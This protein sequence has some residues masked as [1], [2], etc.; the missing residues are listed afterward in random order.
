[1]FPVRPWPPQ[2][3]HTVLIFSSWEVVSDQTNG[4]ATSACWSHFQEA[5]RTHTHTHHHKVRWLWAH[6]QSSRSSVS[7]AVA[8]AWTMDVQHTGPSTVGLHRNVWLQWRW[9][10]QGHA[11]VS[12]NTEEKVGNVWFSSTSLHQHSASGSLFFFV[13][14]IC[15]IFQNAISG[16]SGNQLVRLTPRNR[17]WGWRLKQCARKWQQVTVTPLLKRW[18]EGTMGTI[19][20]SQTTMKTRLGEAWSFCGKLWFHFNT[21]V[22]SFANCEWDRS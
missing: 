21:T 8:N 6:I 18:R 10:E 17:K 5:H 7:S 14:M 1:M 19:P 12:L 4:C 2:R 11:G 9:A 16:W 22:V 15:Y 20:V 3:L 13:F